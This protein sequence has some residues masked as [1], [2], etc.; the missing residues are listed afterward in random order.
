M[1][2]HQN[3]F[4]RRT[5][6]GGQQELGLGQNTQRLSVE[7]PLFKGCQNQSLLSG[8][9]QMDQPGPIQGS[10]TDRIFAQQADLDLFKPESK[11]S[12]SIACGDDNIAH[13]TQATDARDMVKELGDQKV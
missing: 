7:N 3:D 10:Q 11:Q 6:S 9:S 4:S 13:T 2:P 8:F 1:G 5:L 12:H